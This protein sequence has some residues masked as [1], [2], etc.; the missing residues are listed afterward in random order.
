[1]QKKPTTRA[2]AALGAEPF[3]RVSLRGVVRR[4]PQERTLPS[5]DTLI[6]FTVRV[7][8]Y[9]STTG[10]RGTG[11]TVECSAWTAGTRRRVVS[12]QPDDQVEVHGAL[13]RSV[14]GTPTGITSRYEVIVERLVRVPRAKP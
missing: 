6:S 2:G 3:N 4:A 14:R 9:P 12:L 8:R 1:M 7:P 13:R 5:G 11:D 10:P